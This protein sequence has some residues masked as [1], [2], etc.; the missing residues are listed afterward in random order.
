MSWAGLVVLLIVLM[1]A[2]PVVVLVL[3][4]RWLSRDG[5]L[6][7]CSVR[8]GPGRSGWALGVARYSGE[9]LECFRVFS[10][11]FCPRVRV[12]RGR[13]AI[14]AVRD[15][16]PEEQSVLF[17]G[18]R[19]LQIVGADSPDSGPVELAMEPGSLT[20]LMSWLEAAPPGLADREV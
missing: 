19:V 11:S 2:T 10:F 5:G 20:G 7:E 4:R 9:D 1:V 6:F 8:I 16:E 18:Q 13:A 17:A 12:H 3:R 14:V 15:A